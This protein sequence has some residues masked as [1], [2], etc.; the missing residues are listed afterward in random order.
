MK[1]S[2]HF[3]KVVLG[4]T[5][6]FVLCLMKAQAALPSS[7]YSVTDYQPFESPNGIGSCTEK[8]LS[9]LKNPS[10]L[11]IGVA[12]GYSDLTDEHF[13]L[14]TDS[15]TLSTLVNNLTQKCSYLGQGFC[16]FNWVTGSEHDVNMYTR[17][18][19]TID[20]QYVKINVYTMNASYSIGNSDNKTK[21]KSEQEKKTQIAKAFYGW[22]LQNA[23]MVFYEGHSR[24]GGGPDF[25]PP[26]PSHSGTVNYPWY[27]ANKP[28]LK[29]LL[30]SLDAADEKPSR[31]GLF[32]CASRGHFLKSLKSHAPNSKLYLS[33][34]VV[35]A[36]KTKAALMKTL[37]SVMNFECDS[38]LKSRLSGTSFVIEN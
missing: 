24:D 33:T 32:S 16:E 28:G 4:L 25:A 19:Q 10:E 38:E 20:G 14:V 35:E 6:F 23:D 18:I 15:F 26:R 7:A 27:H 5:T 17:T 34:K 3:S 30:A 12:L 13:D 8:I 9:R 36:G 21:Y 22:A 11:T 37:E 31:L 29:F 1:L 2:F